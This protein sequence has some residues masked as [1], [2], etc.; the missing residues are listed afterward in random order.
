MLRGK[1]GVSWVIRDQKR[2]R[3]DREGR[4]KA[5]LRC[6]QRAMKGT[7]GKE[8]KRNFPTSLRGGSPSI[9]LSY[10][11]ASSPHMQR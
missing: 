9:H 11:T 5:D 6:A 2:Q 10:T 3:G 7:T 4:E 1:G 8:R